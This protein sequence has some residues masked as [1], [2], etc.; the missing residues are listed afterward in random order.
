MVLIL[1]LGYTEIW[2]S[3]VGDRILG[4]RLMTSTGITTHDTPSVFIAGWR[5]SHEFAS[6]DPS[7]GGEVFVDISGDQLGVYSECT[8]RNIFTFPICPGLVHYTNMCYYI[9]CSCIYILQHSE[10]Y[11]LRLQQL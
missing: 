6:V 4:Y 2:K 11:Y 7:A 3:D 10:P 1:I 5:R 9:C 8:L